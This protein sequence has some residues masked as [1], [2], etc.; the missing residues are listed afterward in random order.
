MYAMH[1]SSHRWFSIF[2]QCM[3]RYP[4]AKHQLLKPCL[5]AFSFFFFPSFFLSHLNPA[6][7]FNFSNQPFN[8]VFLWIWL[9]FFL[10]LFVLF[11]IIYKI[12]IVFQFQPSLIFFNY[13]SL[14]FFYYYY[15]LDLFYFSISSLIVLF[16]LTFIPDLILILLIAT[17]LFF[18]PFLD[19]CYFSIS[20]LA[21]L[22]YLIVIPNLV[23]IIFIVIWFDFF[24]NFGWLGILL[25]DFYGLAFNKV[26]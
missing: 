2:E 12:E 24:F 26:T 10:L 5:V 7:P 16:H 9:I 25:H 23:L 21:V 20:S 8:L 11:K 15:F 22:F 18:F 19:L 4:L 14:Y 3:W 6:K 1:A 17:F 13:Q